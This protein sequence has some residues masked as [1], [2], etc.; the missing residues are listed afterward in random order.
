MTKVEFNNL[1][2]ECS[3]KAIDFAEY[4]VTNNLPK[5]VIFNVVLNVSKDDPK[6]KRFDIFPEDNNKKYSLIKQQKVV[7]LLFR[8]NKIPVWV[9][10][11]VESIYNNHTVI[12]LFCSGRYSDDSE[13]YYY[14]NN[15]TACFG[16]KSP[17]LPV[18]YIEGEKI[19][20][21]VRNFFSNLLRKQKP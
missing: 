18:D 15:G 20:L 10:I 17:N 9:D 21:T 13:Q 16:V 7:D 3:L 1:L 14:N 6:L 8:N 12:S 4:Y 11:N 19:N 5:K 2:S